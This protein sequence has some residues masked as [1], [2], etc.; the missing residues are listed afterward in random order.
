MNCTQRVNSGSLTSKRMF[1]LAR[2]KPRGGGLLIRSMDENVS[3]NNGIIGLRRRMLQYVNLFE[4]YMIMASRTGAAA[5]NPQSISVDVDTVYVSVGPDQSSA[6]S[7]PPVEW[8][9]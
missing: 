6:T 3:S 2:R 1:P 7:P 9:R 5:C 4:S 8:P